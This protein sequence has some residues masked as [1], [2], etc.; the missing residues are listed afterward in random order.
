M[1][2]SQRRAAI[3]ARQAGQVLRTTDTT[4]GLAQVVERVTSRAG[5]V[6]QAVESP[7]G[8]LGCYLA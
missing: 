4:R 1:S 6:Y 8:E 7:R 3:T 5:D 2:G